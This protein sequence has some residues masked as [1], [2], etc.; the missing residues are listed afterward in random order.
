MNGILVFDNEISAQYKAIM[1][2]GSL[3]KYDEEVAFLNR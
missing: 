2:S 3:R 1:K